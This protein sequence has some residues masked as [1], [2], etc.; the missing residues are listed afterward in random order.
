MKEN[1]SKK[2]TS[3]DDL[4]QEYETNHKVENKNSQLLKPKKQRHLFDIGQITSIL[5]FKHDGELYRQYEGAK[6]IANLEDFVVF[7]NATITLNKNKHN[8][9]YVNL[10]SPFYIDKG[11]LKY[12]DYDIDVKSYIDHEFNQ[13]IVNYKYPIE[14]IYRLY[15]E[16]D[17]LYGQFKVQAGIFSKKLVNGLEKMLKESGDI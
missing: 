4:L 14:L 13:S 11:V 3:F 9:I 15:D 10:S 8:Y 6:I 17:F 7:Y 12:I 2:I 16:L 5:A 1:E